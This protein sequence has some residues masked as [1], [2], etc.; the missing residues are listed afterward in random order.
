LDLRRSNNSPLNMVKFKL[1]ENTPPAKLTTIASFPRHYFLEKA[2]S[3]M[4]S[5]VPNWC[6]RTYGGRIDAFLRRA[7]LLE[8]DLIVRLSKPERSGHP[9]QGMAADRTNREN[10]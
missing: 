6:H 2:P 10:Q 8:H 7:A 5:D 3:Y 9:Y 4:A 1:S